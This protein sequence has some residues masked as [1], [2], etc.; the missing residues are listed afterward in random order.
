MEN[1][2]LTRL[3]FEYNESHS[4]SKNKLIHQFCVPLIMVST[5]GIFQGLIGNRYGIH[6]DLGLFIAVMALYLWL[7][8]RIF[9]QMLVFWGLALALEIAISKTGYLLEISTVVFVLAW[10]GQF[11]GHKIEGKKPS[12]FKDLVFLF[13]GPIW[14][15]KSLT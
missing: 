11:I 13:I 9:L 3:M 8:F 12:F 2:K 10:I 15:W 7:G 5:L 14:V 4:N 1:P 6:L